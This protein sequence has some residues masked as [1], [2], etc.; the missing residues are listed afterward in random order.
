MKGNNVD[1]DEVPALLPEPL[2]QEEYLKDPGRC[3]RCGED[4]IGGGPVDICGNAAHQEM[5]CNHCNAEWTDT[6][7]LSSY[8]FTN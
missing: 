5:S 3:P 2:S 4:D 1:D 7:N 8:A 6:Y